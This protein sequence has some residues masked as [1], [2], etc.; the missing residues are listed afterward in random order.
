MEGGPQLLAG[1]RVQ[2]DGGLVHDEQ[3]GVG[4]ERAG[5]AH[6]S[7]LAAGVGGHGPVRQSGQPDNVE[8]LVQV[9]GPT[10]GQGGE[11][12]QVL[13]GG[14]V[15]VDGL[16]LGDVADPAAHGGGAGGV[17]EDLDLPAVALN[18]NDGAHE[19]GLAAARG[20]EQT[21]DRAGRQ[22][23]VQAVED[24][25]APATHAQVRRGDGRLRRG[26]RGRDVSTGVVRLVAGPRLPG[27]VSFIAFHHVMNIG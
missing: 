10:A 3:V 5:Q 15:S 11:V 16:V 18:P 7:G 22:V 13:A 4:H 2:A 6:A 17:P 8:D 1:D 27:R 24:L 20:T 19:G 23:Q 9:A 14:Q 25:L 12:A 21:G 26:G